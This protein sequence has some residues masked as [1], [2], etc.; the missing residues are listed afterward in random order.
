M[1][2]NTLIPTIALL[3]VSCGGGSSPPPPPPSP[4]NQPPAF[5]SPTSVSIP[6][7]S[8]GPFYVA[9][10]SDPDGTSVSFALT[11]G[12]D[13]AAFTL[14][15][16]T[17]ELSFTNAPDFEAPTDANGDNVYEVTVT[18]SSGGQSTSLTLQ[19]TVTDQADA[20]SVRRL[21]SG[22]SAPIFLTGLPDGS[23]RLAV[24]ERAGRV[25]IMDANTGAIDP[26]P[27]IDITSTVNTDGERGL[28]AIAF[29]PN[30]GADGLVYMHVNNLAGDTEVRT[31]QTLAG[32]T[33]HLD[34]ATADVILNV[35]QP[36]GVLYHKGGL[37]SFDNNGLLLIGIGDGGTSNTAQDTNSLLGKVLRIDVTSDAF[38][39]D[40]DRDYAIPAGNAFPTGA[41]GAPEIWASGLR[42]PFRGSVDAQTGDTFIGDVGENG[43]EEINRIASGA[44]G[45]INFGWNVREGTQPFNGGAD[46]A[47]FTDPVAEYLHGGGDRQGN[48][49][50]GGV[51]YRGPVGELSGE[52]VFADFI[53]NNI[54]SV[55]ITSLAIGQT[56]DSSQFTIRTQDFVP[57]VGS[58][59]SI[60]AFGVDTS[61]NLYVVDIGGEIFKVEAVN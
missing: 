7:G 52:Y 61:Q 41:G 27:M 46:S 16:A 25:L 48:S 20:L 4:A 12:A 45:L 35:A 51:V 28:L 39:G 50:T 9:A 6:E 53:S 10:A 32:Q 54:W 8:T 13:Q 18:A 19:V 59:N 31:Y 43:I 37:F 1:T 55:P 5:S 49:V 17:R 40:A 34:P 47:A 3:L 60:V 21:A 56:L 44:V 2:R 22:L 23:G 26:T 33:D 24:V 58:I 15:S 42:N 57:D 29:S 36:P 30:F 38:P 11:G 14:N